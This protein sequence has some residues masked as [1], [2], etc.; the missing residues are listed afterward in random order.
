MEAGA[1]TTPSQTVGPFFRLGVDELCVDDVSKGDNGPCI[2]IEGTVFDGAGEPVSDALIETWQAD[3][4]GTYP[5]ARSAGEFRGFGRVPTDDNGR[6]RLRTIRPG[7]V[8]APTGAMQA[9]H[10]VVAIFMRGLLKQLVTRIYFE[11]DAMNEADLVLNMVEP[12]RR[13]TLIA[14]RRPGSGETFAWDVH[15]QGQDE[16]VFFDV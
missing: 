13:R 10:L 6:F 9:P 11:H 5:D 15:L 3:S 16:T 12:A 7:P 8:P 4:N 1:G 2:I 14:T